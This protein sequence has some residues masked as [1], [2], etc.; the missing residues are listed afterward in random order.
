MN[1]PKASI[2]RGPVLIVAIVL[3]CVWGF[4]G[5]RDIPKREY[6]EVDFPACAI[7]T[8]W[9]GAAPEKVEQLVTEKVEDAAGKAEDIEKTTSW[10]RTGLS[11]VYAYVDTD[12][13][14]LDKQKIWDEVK[15]EVDRVR[16]QMPE[17]LYF[18]PYVNDRF[19]EVKSM[20]ISLSS[21]ERP[22]SELLDYAESLSDE[23]TY[24]DTVNRSEISGN[25]REVIY[26]VSNERFN[27][28]GIHLIDVMR[29]LAARNIT[30][31]GGIL[32][33][34]GNEMIIE[35]SGEFNSLSEIGDVVIKVSPKTGHTVYLR[36]LFTIKRG[37][38]DPPDQLAH[39][40][41]KRAVLVDVELKSGKNIIRMGEQVEEMLERA[42]KTFPD[43][44]NINVVVNQAEVVSEKLGEFSENLYQGIILV[45]AVA[46]LSIGIRPAVIMAVA[47]PLSLLF[48]FGV[49][50][51][52]GRDMEN[53]V[54]TGL[55]VALG[56]I[57]DNAVVITENIDRYM[58][59]G[60][61]KVRAA[62]TGT[63]EVAVPMLS[64]TATT[65]AAFGP[66]AFIPGTVGEFIVSIPLVVILALSASYVIAITVTPWMCSRIL[67]VQ[68]IKQKPEKSALGEQLPG[69]W[70]RIGR[71]YNTMIG[72]SLKR[73]K[74]VLLSA[75]LVFIVALMLIPKLGFQFFPT[76]EK[77][78]F[79][80]EVWAPE[81]TNV[82]KTRQIAG[83]VEDILKREKKIKSFVTYTGIGSPRIEIGVIQQ[84]LTPNYAMIWVK[85]HD[86]HET[87][88]L[89]P[90]IRDKVRRTVV[91]AR[92]EVKLLETGPP[93][94]APVSI[95]IEGENID[96]LRRL[97]EQVQR[98]IAGQKG[99]FAI[100]DDFGTN[101]YKINGDFDEDEIKRIGL[102]NQEIALSLMANFSGLYVT[103]FREGDKTVPIKLK[104]ADYLIDDFNDLAETRVRS[105]ITN[106]EIALKQVAKINAKPYVPVIRHKNGKR[107]LKVN[108]FVEE[109]VLADNIIKNIWPDI[110]KLK[111]PE[112]YH[113]KVAGE[114]EE[115]AKAFSRIS[116]A[117]MNAIL[118]MLLVLMLNFN[119]FK[120]TL[121]IFSTIPL[122][123]VGSV[124]GLFITGYPFGFMAFLGVV[125]LS[126]IVVNNA[127]ILIDFIDHRIEDGE[128]PSF[129]IRNAGRLR[130]RPIFVTT[131]TT[132]G[133]M[134]P[135]G[136][137]GGP[138]FAPMAWVIIFGLATS[139]VLTLIVVPNL[140]YVLIGRKLE[141]AMAA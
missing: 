47:I 136:L 3:I 5:Y 80:V 39:V 95:E 6:P 86:W 42:R 92:V 66:L 102:T 139:A 26:L 23:L 10:S 125:A 121:I 74:L 94:G 132:M 1:I 44:V 93:V 69:W 120:K 14:F 127:I 40:N 54:I 58:Q 97:S 8:I 115:R 37:L 110:E 48:T 18:G 75:L 61:D 33:L 16:D 100:H 30:M 96:I 2:Q 105:S 104:A 67:V 51:L 25:T 130:M 101:A 114:F 84:N 55:I 88:D 41:G 79:L 108:A 135:L 17:G 65:I 117:F 59:M 99:V 9:P 119:S 73:P 129:S 63:G 128:R 50:P 27:E 38:E 76:A 82:N 140:Y 116:R 68:K 12:K 126:G 29:V 72:V 107:T 137:A 32:S 43:D 57:V 70:G 31:S 22:Y 81:G 34:S 124:T 21:D 64:A 112:G 118:L 91:G 90:V 52:I 113:L 98:L 11:V 106:K 111:V 60:Y 109:G 24:L 78:L 89:V 53:M 19:S 13:L 123:L 15:E 46:L 20:L 56:M 83:Q 131:A 7:V 87:N 77:D 141:A 49:L 103:D 36:D 45:L 62:W 28:Y 122:S 35:P 134:L 138:L 4:I 133:G 85:T 71:V